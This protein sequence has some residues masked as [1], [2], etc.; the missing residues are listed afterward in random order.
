MVLVIILPTFGV[1]VRPK[2]YGIGVFGWSCVEVLAV[3][4]AMYRGSLRNL[5]MRV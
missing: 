1:H 3:E 4:G 2:V 5:K